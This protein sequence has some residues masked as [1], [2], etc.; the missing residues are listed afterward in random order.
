[1]KLG[2]ILKALFGNET[3]ALKDLF[4]FK[5]LDRF[6]ADTDVKHIIKWMPL[7]SRILLPYNELIAGN[8]PKVVPAILSTLKIGNKGQQIF[9]ISVFKNLMHTYIL[10]FAQI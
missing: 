1:M 7:L 10:D 3:N 2:I 4:K 8:L 5:I 9:H 6:L